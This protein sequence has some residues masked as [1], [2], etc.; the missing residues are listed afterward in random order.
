[1][2]LGFEEIT[3]CELHRH[4][5]VLN[6]DLCDRL[7]AWWLPAGQST[8]RT[9]NF[10]IVSTCVIE[11]RP[12]LLLVEAKA[13]ENELIRESVGR[14]V[15][16]DDPMN[17]QLQRQTSQVTIG[18]AIE[19]ASERLGAETG[20]TF[21]LSVDRC[22]QMSNRFAWAWKLADSGIPVVLIYLGFLKANEMASESRP[23]ETHDE[24]E[25]LVRSESN[26]VVPD[27]IW[28]RIWGVRGQSFIPIIRSI[29]Q[30]LQASTQ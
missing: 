27:A 20:L 19:Q 25:T 18:A 4:S 1:M 26:A 16:L 3:E 24:W 15:A 11:D 10:D 6:T 21:K 8:D 22:Y 7:A 30:P 14:K 13:H 29:D 2:P 28:N 17:P 9:P 12:G 23:F 5:R